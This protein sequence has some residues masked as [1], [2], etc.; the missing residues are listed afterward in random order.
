[1]DS[2]RNR[3]AGLNPQTG[4]VGHAAVEALWEDIGSPLARIVRRAVRSGG[5]RSALDRKIL[6]QVDNVRGEERCDLDRLVS[7]VALRICGAMA[8][9]KRACRD[10]LMKETVCERL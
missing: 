6:A 7:R 4:S 3:S 1:M 10:Q 2:A 9:Q 8:V 5:G